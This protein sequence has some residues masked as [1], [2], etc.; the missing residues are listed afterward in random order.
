MRGLWVSGEFFSTLRL[1]P[2]VG[3]L[4]IPADDHRGCG[5]PGAVISH[6]FWQSEYANDPSVIGRRINVNGH[7]VAILG[8]APRS[9]FGIDAG[10]T[11]QVA[12]PVCSM[13]QIR[14]YDLLSSGTVW[15]LRV[16]GRLRQGWT[17]ERAAA[18]LAAVS[19][20]I[21][22]DLCLETIQLPT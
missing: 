14:G 8:V 1:P 17:I 16:I 4:F 20:E 2:T 22:Q 11:F 13:A 19:P 9:F 10:H 21:F 12:L 18:Q 3:R 6:S 5:V 15:Q 7:P